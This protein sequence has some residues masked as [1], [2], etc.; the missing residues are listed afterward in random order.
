MNREKQKSTTIQEFRQL[1]GFLS[2]SKRFWSYFVCTVLLM[3]LAAGIALAEPEFLRRGV[4]AIENGNMDALLQVGV[5]VIVFAVLL[6]AQ[7]SIQR[8]YDRSRKNAILEDIQMQAMR[9]VLRLK[10]AELDNMDA[11]NVV[12][13]IV[14]NIEGA[15]FDGCYCLAQVLRGSITILACLGYMAF[16]DW[17]LALGVVV[18]NLG[19]RAV[20]AFFGDRIKQASE[21]MVQVIKRN[22]SFFI[23]LLSNMITMRCFHRESYFVHKT[24]EKEKETLKATMKEEAW[25]MTFFEFIWMSMKTCEYV[26]MYGLGGYLVYLGYSS[27]AIVSAFV[28]VAMM[29]VEGINSFVWGFAGIKRSVPAIDSAAV[30][31]DNHATEEEQHMAIEEMQLAIRCEH[32]NFSYGEKQV[33]HDI[34]FTIREG[35][36]VLIKGKNGSGKST[37]LNIIAG[38]YRPDSGHVYYGCHDV[39]DIH[40]E[41]LSEKYAYIS[42]KSNIL[43]G[44]VYENLTFSHRYDKEMLNGILQDLHLSRAADT[45]PKLLSQGEKQRLNIGRALYRKN[46]VSILLGDELF[47]NIDK[48]N[49]TYIAHLLEQKF[50]DKTVIFVCHEDVDFQFDRVFTME[51][52][53]LKEGAIA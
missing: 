40:I 42:Q 23:D 8:L 34:S 22:N 30:I 10:K 4:A 13:S 33:L 41:D 16:I 27:I 28:A 5:L 18:F 6:I 17:R 43:E 47:A 49:V 3:L 44:N 50:S 9:R 21:Q 48:E 19:T 37:L 39:T 31:L 12:T 11:G 24:E 14:N 45:E 2:R 29:L 26:I 51:N 7:S 36:K 53:I 32:I 1:I 25:E 20:I 38:L 15:V 46:A 52:G 35:E